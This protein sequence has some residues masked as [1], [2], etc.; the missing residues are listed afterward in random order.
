MNKELITLGIETSCDETAASVV[1]G[2]FTELSSVVASQDDIHNKFGGIVPELACRRHSEL[3]DPV[4]KSAMEKAGVGLEDIDIVAVTRGPGLVGALLVGLSYAKAL[5]WGLG[6]P[7]VC[8]NHL[9]GHIFSALLERPDT[10]LPLVA[11]VVSGGHTE[12]FY[13]E[14]IGDIK[15]LGGTRDDAA[16]EAFDK[17]AKLL[18][19]GYPGGP[20]VEKMAA[21]GKPCIPVPVALMRSGA[22]EFSFSGPKTAVKLI[23]QGFDNRGEA[24]PVGD[25]CASFQKAVIKALTVKMEAAVEK[26][27]P[28]AIT[29]AGGVACN[30]ALRAEMR[31]LGLRLGLPVTIALPYLCSD[32]AVMIAAVGANHYL[33]DPAAKEWTDYMEADA[34]P[35]W[36]PGL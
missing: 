14:K 5:A 33:N 24:R 9:E 35:G 11:L 30:G 19:M 13:M 17:V 18:G 28:K 12:L 23:V 32:N 8:V 36:I 3:I 20:E 15:W 34:D 26:T 22:L 31:L 16:G 4:V 27:S 1:R 2:R 21:H 10:P 6:K 25:I 29:I 7:L